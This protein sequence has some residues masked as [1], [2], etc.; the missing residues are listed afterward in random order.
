M[1]KLRLND[2]SLRGNVHTI[3]LAAEQFGVSG[4]VMENIL[5]SIYNQ[6]GA[7]DEFSEK[8]RQ[9][10]TENPE[11]PKVLQKGTRWLNDKIVEEAIQSDLLK[12]VEGGY[13]LT[14]KAISVFQR[15]S[16]IQ[17]RVWS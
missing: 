4:H 9:V 16:K 10:I 1:T 6:L 5:I 2:I 3:Y 17:K 11:Y 8:G 15:A 12:E 13:T 7:L 14:K